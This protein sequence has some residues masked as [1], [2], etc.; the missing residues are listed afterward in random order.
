MDRKAWCA[1]THGV[2]KSQTRLSD[3][4]DWLTIYKNKVKMDLS[5]RQETI[6]LL[7]ENLGRTVFDINW[8]NIFVLDLS[9]K[10]KEMKAK[11]NKW[12][13]I[14][15]KSFGTAKGVIKTKRLP[16][17]WENIFDNNRTSKSLISKIYK[18]LI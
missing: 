13:L 6:K 16:T 4:T 11:I 10:A 8:N 3:W 5:V 9:P 14:K 15:L 7:E 12:E 2:A 18:Q 1:A 17:E